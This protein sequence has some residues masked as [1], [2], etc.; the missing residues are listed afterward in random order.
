MADEKPP[1]LIDRVKSAMTEFV[2]YDR[3]LGIPD[4]HIAQALAAAVA[5]VMA[6]PARRRRD[7]RGN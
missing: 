5:E 2:D 4:A 1:L 7:R 6:A 3:E